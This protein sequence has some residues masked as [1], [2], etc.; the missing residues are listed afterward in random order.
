MHPL[1]LAALHGHDDMVSVLIENGAD[2]TVK[3]NLQRNCLDI[4]LEKGHR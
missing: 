1:L 3:D 2:V 4:A